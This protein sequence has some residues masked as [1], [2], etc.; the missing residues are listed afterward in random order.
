MSASVRMA[1]IEIPKTLSVHSVA[2]IKN[3]INLFS[4]DSLDIIQTTI[5]PKTWESL[6][7]AMDLSE[8]LEEAHLFSLDDGSKKALTRRLTTRDFLLQAIDDIITPFLTGKETSAGRKTIYKKIGLVT[9]AISFSEDYSY[10]EELD[11][12][13]ITALKASNVLV[14]KL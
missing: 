5:G 3:N 7:E 4:N 13:M 6:H 14:G 9:Y 8:R 10:R 1:M 2:K 11:Y 12:Y